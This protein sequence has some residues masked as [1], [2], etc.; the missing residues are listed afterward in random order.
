MEARLTEFAESLLKACEPS[1]K[2]QESRAAQDR[3]R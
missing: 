3:P 2:P 1:F